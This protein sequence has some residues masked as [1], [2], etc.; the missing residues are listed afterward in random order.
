MPQASNCAFCFH[1]QVNPH[2]GAVVLAPNG[3]VVCRRG[4]EE[5][6]SDPQGLRFPYMLTDA[7]RLA[8]WRPKYLSTKRGPIDPRAF[9]RGA[10]YVAIY[11]TTTATARLP[12]CLD[13][14]WYLQRWLRILAERN[15]AHAKAAMR[16]SRRAAREAFARG[17][18][19][20][21]VGPG[22]EMVLPLGSEGE[23]S[24]GMLAAGGASMATVG[25]GSTG[26]GIMGGEA[27]LAGG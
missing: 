7:V 24:L 23:G 2:Y 9:F 6:A 20:M 16:R 19:S 26:E 15:A 4:I 5:I 14:R 17:P 22:G 10:Q 1:E 21:G 27:S 12:A 18:G 3:A 8:V 25:T 11:C 13:S